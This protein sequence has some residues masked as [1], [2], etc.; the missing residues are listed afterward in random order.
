MTNRPAL[1]GEKS[2]EPKDPGASIGANSPH[3][4]TATKPDIVENAVAYIICL[5]QELQK[6]KGG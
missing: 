6:L 4:T 5:Q 3:A 2:P 1:P